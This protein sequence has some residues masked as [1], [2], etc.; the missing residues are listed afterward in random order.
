MWKSRILFKTSRLNQCKII[1]ENFFWFSLILR[2]RGAHEWKKR[3]TEG[4]PS[5]RLNEAVSSRYHSHFLLI[6]THVSDTISIFS[7]PHSLPHTYKLT[8]RTRT[9]ARNQRKKKKKPRHNFY[10][11]LR[12]LRPNEKYQS[13][14]WP[15]SNFLIL[16]WKYLSPESFQITECG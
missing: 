2:E 11:K 1:F 8:Q 6:C 14:F 13:F 7:T 9:H 16:D 12:N 5:T 4:N 15:Y 3:K 10:F